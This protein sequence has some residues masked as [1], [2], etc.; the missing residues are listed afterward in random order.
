MKGTDVALLALGGFVLY[1]FFLKPQPQTVVY[2]PAAGLPLTS[3][4]STVSLATTLLTN[5]GKLVNSN[6]PVSSQGVT[7]TPISPSAS[8]SA[9][10]PLTSYEAGVGDQST[11]ILPNSVAVTSGSGLSQGLI[12]PETLATPSLVTAPETPGTVDTSTLTD[13]STSMD[14]IFSSQT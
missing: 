8:Q 5:L 6:A 10:Q 2:K 7:F 11:M 1:E 13:S 4:A 14:S 12:T 3:S 9:S